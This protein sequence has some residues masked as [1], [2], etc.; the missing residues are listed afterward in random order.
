[1]YMYSVSTFPYL[2]CRAP[3]KSADSLVS[4]HAHETTD[5]HP[6]KMIILSDVV[7]QSAVSGNYG[8][9]KNAPGVA[10]YFAGVKLIPPGR[11]DWFV[12]GATASTVV[13]CSIWSEVQLANV[14]T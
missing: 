13:E 2:C 7:V 9:K 8:E 12:P 6:A 5:S 1:M 10:W 11:P 3:W 14:A 4:T